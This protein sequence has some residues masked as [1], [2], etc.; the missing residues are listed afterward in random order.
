MKKDVRLGRYLRM[1]LDIAWIHNIPDA[2]PSSFIRGVVGVQD[3]ID[4]ID[5]KIDELK[6]ARIS[7]MQE[8]KQAV[9]DMEARLLQYM[10][11]E[12]LR[13]AKA[14]PVDSYWLEQVSE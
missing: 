5:R 9:K 11:K 2:N 7:L 8:R 4:S 1:P 6:A 12:E 14:T 3:S 13:I 10:T